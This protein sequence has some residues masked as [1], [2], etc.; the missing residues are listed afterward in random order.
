[1][2]VTDDFKMLKLTKDEPDANPD[3][4]LQLPEQAA[5]KQATSPQCQENASHLTM[6][7]Q[8][9]NSKTRSATTGTGPLL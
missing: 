5:T 9:A 2:K 1:M 4:K 3:Q 6:H 7:G 8:P